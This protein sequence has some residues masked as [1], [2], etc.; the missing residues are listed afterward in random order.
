MIASNAPSP[1]TTTTKCDYWREEIRAVGSG[2][3]STNIASALVV[4]WSLAVR[5]NLFLQSC[6]GLTRSIGACRTKRHKA[7]RLN[8]HAE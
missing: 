7:H 2:V 3:P 5:I 1:I 8:G 6:S 4:L